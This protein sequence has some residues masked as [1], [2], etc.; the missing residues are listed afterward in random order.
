M[1]PKKS[2]KPRPNVHITYSFEPS[3][4]SVLSDVL[5]FIMR[6]ETFS[7]EAAKV[8]ADSA[9]EAAEKLS[10]CEFTFTRGEIRAI[11]AGIK[12]ALDVLPISTNDFS[13]MEEDFPGLVAN[14]RNNVPLL[15]L[16]HAEFQREVQS[17]RKI[18]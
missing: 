5:D 3:E 18:K 6:C 2:K 10:I 11:A 4:A 15:N 7:F 16:L 12:F 17:L 14:L 9:F 1:K 13:Y 8:S